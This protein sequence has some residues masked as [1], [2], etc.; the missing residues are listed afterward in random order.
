MCVSHIWCEI[1]IPAT[2]RYFPL[3]KKMNATE[4]FNI[5]IFIYINVC[6]L[7]L[8]LLK[9]LFP[10]FGS[11]CFSHGPTALPPSFLG[12]NVLL[13]Q[14]GK[15]TS[16]MATNKGRFAHTN[17][18]THTDNCK[19]KSRSF[20]EPYPPPLSGSSMTA[21]LHMSS[22]CRVMW[23]L[24]F[25]PPSCSPVWTH[26]KEP[27]SPDSS[28]PGF[29]G[30]GPLGKA[31]SHQLDPQSKMTTQQ[32][33]TCSKN[34]MHENHTVGKTKQL[35]KPVKLNVYKNIIKLKLLNSRCKYH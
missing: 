15:L 16:G 6:T 12:L 1:L 23:C 14:R 25:P 10:G 5:F 24:C 19:F 17:T 35:V 9:I 26:L 7:Q 28:N 34:K 21:V 11:W 2:K 32:S 30:C 31:V 8:R 3:L 33:K 29:W 27:S 13:L 18:N 22:L 4:R 20:T